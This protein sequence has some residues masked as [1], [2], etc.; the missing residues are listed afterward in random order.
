LEFG[1]SRS[2]SLKRKDLQKGFRRLNR[3]MGEAF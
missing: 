1:P 3:L 2:F